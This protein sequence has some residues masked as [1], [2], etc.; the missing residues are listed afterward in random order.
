MSSSSIEA[1]KLRLLNFKNTM[2]NSINSEFKINNER[3]LLNMQK[4]IHEKLE[5]NSDITDDSK[6][7]I[8]ELFISEIDKLNIELNNDS[9]IIIKDKLMSY[10]NKILHMFYDVKRHVDQTAESQ[11]HDIINTDIKILNEDN[12]S[13]Y[14]DKHIDFDINYNNY[15]S[16][17]YLFNND[18]DNDIE[19]YIENDIQNDIQNDIE[20]NFKTDFEYEMENYIE[21][22]D[23]DGDNND[24][25]NNDGDN[26]DG[27]N[28]DDE[29]NNDINFNKFINRFNLSS[30][31]N[32]EIENNEID[33]N[34]T[35]IINNDIP[36]TSREQELIEH[37]VIEIRKIAHDLGISIKDKEA[38][39]TKTKAQLIKEIIELEIDIN[40]M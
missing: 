26:E 19:N 14:S 25:D 32:D 36:M 17:H 33:I 29:V 13:K 20:N 40:Y 12:I 10:D 1:N 3:Y 4:R 24:G 39:K 15:N 5:Q 18:S 22:S 37:N 2:L 11:L 6:E 8:N 28:D 35:D 9:E 23:N 21:N 31:N 27:D 30:V 7:F 34:S 16:Q 38:N